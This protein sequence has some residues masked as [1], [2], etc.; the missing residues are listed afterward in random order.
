MAGVIFSSMFFN[1]GTPRA[2]SL[3]QPAKLV[4]T[5]KFNG[6]EPMTE[7]T[8]T[9][10]IHGY[11]TLGDKA[12]GRHLL[13]GIWVMPNGTEVEHSKIYLD[14]PPPGRQ[15]AYVWLS[16]QDRSSGTLGDLRTGSGLEENSPYH[17]TW[18]VLI[19]WNEQTLTGAK[20]KVKC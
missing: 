16:F 8:C 3:W 5:N 10:T 18:T 19:R 1:G 13:E 15:T 12:V 20:F 14:F 7:F 11:V 9:D 4:L 17:G 2:A 6:L